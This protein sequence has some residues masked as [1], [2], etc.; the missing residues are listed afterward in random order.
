MTAPSDAERAAL[1][2]LCVAVQCGLQWERACSVAEVDVDVARRAVGQWLPS[3]T[4]DAK[5]AP[6]AR[7]L[8]ALIRSEAIY[9]VARP[10]WQEA[11]GLRERAAWISAHA[12]DADDERMAN[13]MRREAIVETTRAKRIEALAKEQ[14]DAE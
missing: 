6:L 1:Y 14:T 7:R 5:L 13:D 3:P 2:V 4:L 10:H 12:Y 8:V 9:E 11:A